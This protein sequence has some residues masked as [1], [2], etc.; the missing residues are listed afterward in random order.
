M[1][2]RSPFSG[3]T[4]PVSGSDEAGTPARRLTEPLRELSV[5]ALLGGNAVFLLLGVCDLLFVID[6]WAGGFG[7]RSEATFGVFMGLF[8]LGL[9]MAALLLATHVRPMIPRTRLAMIIVLC[10]YAVSAVFGAITYLGAF[11]YDLRSPRATVEGLLSRSVWLA[12]F[13]LGS[14]LAAR[15][16][17]GLF[18]AAAKPAGYPGYGQPTY[19]RPY[20]GQ[21]MYPQPR[22]ATPPSAVIAPT[23]GLPLVTDGVERYE[24]DDESG[25]P[26]VPA[27]PQPM[28]VEIEADPTMRIS[29][30]RQAELLGAEETQLVPPPLPAPEPAPTS[31]DTGSS[32]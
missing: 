7:G 27:P 12:F 1:T 24:D 11:A 4:S 9:P 14:I 6:D 15:V 25:W 23:M 32:A 20:P 13:V 29:L 2:L 16:W 17:L 19:G 31:G 5:F 8:G 30:P 21:P 26:A 22:T 18:P 10:E 3:L 28:P